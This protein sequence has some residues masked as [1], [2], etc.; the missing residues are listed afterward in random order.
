M[1]F[2]RTSFHT[3]ACWLTQ[4]LGYDA[5]GMRKKLHG[6]QNFDTTYGQSLCTTEAQLAYMQARRASLRGQST[7]GSCFPLNSNRVTSIAPHHQHPIFNLLLAG[8]Q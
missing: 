8:C 1:L 4:T 2:L 3:C 5:I 7:R 6:R